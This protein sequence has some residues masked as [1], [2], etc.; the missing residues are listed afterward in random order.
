MRLSLIFALFVLS[1]FVFAE[2]KSTSSQETS[3]PVTGEKAVSSHKI[4]EVVEKG[5]K[6]LKEL[7]QATSKPTSVNPAPINGLYEAAIGSEVFYLSADGSYFVAG[8]IYEFQPKKEGKSVHPLNLTDQK[9]TSLRAGVLD[10]L[11]ESE[12]VVFT[13]ESETKHTVNVFTDVDCGYCAKLHLEVP[14]LNEAGV[15]VRYLA[16]PRAGIGSPT[17][18]KMVSVW[19]ADDRQ[20]AMTDTKAGQKIEE[21]ECKNSIEKQYNLGQRIGIRGTPAIMLSSG[22]L[23]PGYMPALKLITRLEGKE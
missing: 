7:L 18:K 2:E 22:E 16:F 12:M 10:E 3:T 14:K 4:P 15:K 11:E 8:N 23:I 17:Y 19:C 1:S 6:H 9:R 13:P 20:Q 5:L 21:R